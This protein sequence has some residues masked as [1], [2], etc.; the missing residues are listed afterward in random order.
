MRKHEYQRNSE[1]E[2]KKRGSK[3]GRREGGKNPNLEKKSP[4]KKNADW[5]RFFPLL[6]Y[7]AI[8][9]Y[10]VR[11]RSKSQGQSPKG[12]ERRPIVENP[13]PS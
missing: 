10:P 9:S 12:P 6:D 8:V 11:F 5:S 4:P 13:N 7:P 1:K 2:K 3:E